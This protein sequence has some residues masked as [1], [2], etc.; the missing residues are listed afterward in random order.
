MADQVVVY[1]NGRVVGVVPVAAS[2]PLWRGTPAAAGQPAWGVGT[3]LP[4]SNS[5]G[6]GAKSG[7]RDEQSDGR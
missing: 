1:E 3:L 5:Q 4:V 2:V 6:S 7:R